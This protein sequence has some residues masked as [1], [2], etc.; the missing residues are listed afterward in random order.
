MGCVQTKG[1]VGSAEAPVNKTLLT[2]KQH[3]KG[4]GTVTKKGARVPSKLDDAS[5]ESALSKDAMTHHTDALAQSPTRKDFNAPNDNPL[6]IPLPPTAGF[7]QSGPQSF[8]NHTSLV[9]SNEANKPVSTVESDRKHLGNVKEKEFTPLTFHSSL[10]AQTI[11]SDSY[12]K[13]ASIYSGLSASTT[14]TFAPAQSSRKLAVVSEEREETKSVDSASTK[15]MFAIPEVPEAGV[16]LENALHSVVDASE[17]LWNRAHATCNGSDGTLDEN[18]DAFKS[19]RTK[20]LSRA[21]A[22]C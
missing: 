15:R 13:P 22:C 6:L 18:G 12:V 1:K 14:F 7:S 11:T 21:R 2:S 20:K 5:V 3:R 8:P 4:K 19:L 9:K 10:S 16:L 17:N